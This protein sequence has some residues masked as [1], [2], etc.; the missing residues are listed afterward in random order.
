MIG[1]VAK[2]ILAASTTG[3]PEPFRTRILPREVRRLGDAFGLKAIG[4]SLVTV[5]PGKESSMRHHHSHE[6][7]LVYVLEGELVLRTDAGDERLTAGMVVAFAAGDGNGH[8]LVNE[9][10]A[11]AV[12][13]V[14]SNRHA[15]DTV[16]YPD[17][18]LAA[19]KV[20]GAYVFMP[21]R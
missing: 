11:N 16:A 13:L 10:D 12:F 17:V 6:D 4:V 8:Q 2:E 15:D 14:A 18:D 1:R 21:K 9:S 5:F 3:Y 19:R 20:D 7:E